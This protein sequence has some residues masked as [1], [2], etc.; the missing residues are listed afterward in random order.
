MS[1]PKAKLTPGGKTAHRHA[2]ARARLVGGPQTAEA[3]GV[4]W[5]TVYRRPGRFQ[6]EGG[7]GLCD[8]SWRRAAVRQALGARAVET[9]LSER[10]Q[11]R[12]G[13]H[14]PGSRP[15]HP[16]FVLRRHGLSRPSD[17]DRTTTRKV[18]RYRKGTA[19]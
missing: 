5:A 2:C 6:K 15:G 7:A 14:Q 4:S 12:L 1:H 10:R 9:I 18:I 8:R 3:Q 13:P 11:R 19:G 17:L 16:R